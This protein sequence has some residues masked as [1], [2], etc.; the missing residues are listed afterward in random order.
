MQAECKVILDNGKEFTIEKETSLKSIVN[1]YYSNHDSKI[2]AFKLNYNLQELSYKLHKEVNKLEVID[3]NHKDGIRIYQRSLVF[4]FSRAVKE[5]YGKDKTII[6]HS[7]SKGLYCEIGKELCT[8]D[9][10]NIEDKMREIV[11]L[12]EKFIKHTIPKEEAIKKYLKWGLED[13][14]KLLE[15]REEDTVNIYEFGGMIDYYY[16]YMA[17]SAG[18]LDVFELKQYGKGIIIRHPTEYSNGTLPE[19]EEHKKLYHIHREAEEWAKILG[20]SYIRNINDLIKSGEIGNK[21]LTVEALHEKKII[22]IADEI[23]KKNKRII[24]IAGPSSSGKTTFANRLKIQLAVNGLRPVTISVDDYFVNRENNPVDENGKVDFE[25]IDAIDRHRF[26]TDIKSL[27]AGNK[28]EL[29]RF[30]F[31]LGKRK[32]ETHAMQ[33]DDDQPIIIEGI[34]CLN[35]IFSEEIDDEYKFKIYISCLTQLNIDEHNRIPTTDS[36]LIRRMVRDNYHRGADALRTIDLWS[37]VRRGEERN[38]FPYQETADA[39][40]NSASIYELAALKKHVEPVL[41]AVPDNLPETSE[42]KRLLKF[43]SYVVPIEDE[44]IIPNTAIIREFIGG[45]I[46]R[47]K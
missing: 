28:T 12:D 14:A 46:F 7:L 27:L 11:A 3:L 15:Y 45:N 39:Q 25:H 22:Q 13:K 1:K 32:N 29:P 31:K 38:I 24:L 43:L 4:V 35:P 30:D 23:C 17:Y 19:F 20:V 6:Q 47:E 10:K 42:A 36:R 2:M 16:G 21:I 44:S 33:V 5:L 9:V 37:S 26:N 34:H 18:I 40:F 41:K 8:Q